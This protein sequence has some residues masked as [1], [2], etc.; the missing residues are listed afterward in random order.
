MAEAPSADELLEHTDWLT[1]LAR[2]L[3][4]D[5]S[6]ADVVQETYEVALTRPPKT[7]G[8]LRPWLGGVA[9][10]L[11]KMTVRGRV[12]RERREDAVAIDEPREVPT[13]AQLVERAQAHGQVAKLVLE[14][15][16]PLRAT[17]LLRFFEGLSAAEI[18]RAQGVPESTVR[19]RIKDALDSVRA[20]LDQ[21]HGD[22]KR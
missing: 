18:A 22:R 1:Q 4:G 13:P 12:R 7:D 3:V 19:G 14:L 9:R 11:A 2:A 20:S 6:A 5:A 8:A 21:Q 10:N 15:P 17:L 16:E